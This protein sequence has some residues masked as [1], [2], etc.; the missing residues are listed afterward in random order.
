MYDR[1]TII[2]TLTDGRQI[3]VGFTDDLPTIDL[4]ILG[5]PD[6]LEIPLTEICDEDDF[7]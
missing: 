1:D 3:R 6:D 7:K 2:F 5:I 4:S